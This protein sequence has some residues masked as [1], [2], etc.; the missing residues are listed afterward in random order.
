V[1]HLQLWPKLIAR[2]GY[3]GV[4][5]DCDG[6]HVRRR[7]PP[8]SPSSS[9][10]ARATASTARESASTRPRRTSEASRF[11]LR[12]G[13][14]A[15]VK[16]AVFY[17]GSP[18]A[19]ADAPRA[20]GAGRDGGERSPRVRDAIRALSSRVLDERRAVDVRA[21]HRAAAR[22]D[23][24]ADNDASRATI[25]RTLAF[26]K[27]HLEPLPQP[28]WQ[29]SPERAMLAA[30]YGQRRGRRRL[31]GEW[32]RR[33][34]T[35]RRLRRARTGALPH[36]ARQRRRR[37]ISEG[38][39]ARQ[40]RAR[41]DGC[42]G[43]ELAARGAARGRG[44]A[45]ARAIAREWYAASSTATSA[46]RC[47]CSAGTRRRCRPTSARSSSAS[48]PAADAGPR[49]LQ[50]RLRLCALGA[51]RGA[52][53]R[54]GGARSSSASA[55]AARTRRRADLKPLHEEERFQVALERL[56]G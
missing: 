23:A 40:R 10:R 4:S 48:R 5:M 49:E 28:S 8:C 27:S 24:F 20:A 29:P 11:L 39:R 41:R 36:A 34:P 25:Q 22:F 17:Y 15:N 1:G 16:A 21:R 14:P 30:M 42:L 35:T 19:A 45:H 44:R 2:S 12:D 52:I 37:P 9:A 26:W 32:I 46:T 6:E 7:W 38:A 47:S 13:A 33:T 31:L 55:R 54:R 3:G 18:E 43:M 50:P 56:G 51:H 53:G